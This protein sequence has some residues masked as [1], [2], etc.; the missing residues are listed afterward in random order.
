M[1]DRQLIFFTSLLDIFI[2]QD[3]VVLAGILFTHASGKPCD[4]LYGQQHSRPLV[5]RVWSI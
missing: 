3:G 4:A 1:S 5:L 2:Q